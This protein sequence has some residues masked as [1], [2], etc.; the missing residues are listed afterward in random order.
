MAPDPLDDLLGL[1]Q[2]LARIHAQPAATPTPVPEEADLPPALTEVLA[3]GLL[4]LSL[5]GVDP[6]RI[7]EFTERARR[8]GLRRRVR[9]FG[10]HPRGHTWF[11]VPENRDGTDRIFVFDRSGGLTAREVDVAGF[12]AHCVEVARA[13][14]ERAAAV[15]SS[16]AAPPAPKAVVDRDPITGAPRKRARPVKV[17][18]PESG[19][20]TVVHSGGTLELSGEALGYVRWCLQQL[21][22]TTDAPAPDL[23][24]WE[25]RCLRQCGL[26]AVPPPGDP[27]R[28]EYDATWLRL[29]ARDRSAPGPVSHQIAG[30][31]LAAPGVW[32]LT[33]SEL[34]LLRRAEKAKPARHTPTEAQQ[35]VWASWAEI[36]RSDQVTLTVR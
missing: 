25:A 17:A 14:V 18:I 22:L 32:P 5:Q 1:S 3:S 31:K 19:G 7:G 9:V 8:R 6:T 34:A 35:A 29:T 36:V 4:A 12:L 28:A 24:R 10:W 23:S 16:E 2:A 26:D 30:W 13:A 11:A 27:Q 15:E 21:E 33:P 20:A